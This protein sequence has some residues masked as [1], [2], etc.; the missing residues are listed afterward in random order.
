MPVRSVLVVDD[1]PLV[2]RAVCELF[3]R[4]GDFDVCGEAE[5]WEGGNRKGS[6]APPNLIVT[7]LSMLGYRW[8][9]VSG[10]YFD[11]DFTANKPSTYASGLELQAP[12]RPRLSRAT[13]TSSSSLRAWP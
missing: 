4:E 9:A 13:S 5:K 7:D 1:N 8:N 12:H 11:D 3:T 10:M 2:R 6:T